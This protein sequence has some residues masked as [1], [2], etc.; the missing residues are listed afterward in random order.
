MR[1]YQLFK[2]KP[3]VNDKQA[4]SAHTIEVDSNLSEATRNKKFDA[5]EFHNFINNYPGIVQSVS[6]QDINTDLYPV[7]MHVIPVGKFI[8]ISKFNSMATLV[9]IENSDYIFQQGDTVEK[10]S[11]NSSNS[12]NLL[13][14]RIIFKSIQDYS[15]FMTL[16]ILKFAGWKISE[17]K[18]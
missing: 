14:F 11:F 18:L 17:K 3:S 12:N 13:E 1:Y 8:G 5:D 15:K 10:F 4:K 6:E 16:L 7:M 2:N 9:N